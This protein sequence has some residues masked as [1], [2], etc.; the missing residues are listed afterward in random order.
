MTSAKSR[1]PV[2]PW[3]S[4]AITV[5]PEV[6]AIVGVPESSPPEESVRPTGRLPEAKTKVYGAV[7]PVAERSWLYA[8]PTVPV[9]SG[10]GASR[11][12]GHAG[13][14]MTSAKSR[15]PVH[16]WESVAIT[17]KLEVPAMVG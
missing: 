5:K 7:P 15:L 8:T 2:H 16:P 9:G 3:E 13:G 11:I 10:E 6:P 14:F 12:V 4:V 17:V 1:L